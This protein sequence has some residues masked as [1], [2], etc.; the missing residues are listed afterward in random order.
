MH[1]VVWCIYNVLIA[2]R[3]PTYP[4]VEFVNFFTSVKFPIFFKFAREKR[5]DCDIFG[6]LLR[7][8]DVLLIYLQQIF[9]FCA[10]IYSNTN[11]L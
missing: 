9:S 11:P 4:E 6:Q 10:A 2:S 1:I 3:G 7:M 5:I 8:W